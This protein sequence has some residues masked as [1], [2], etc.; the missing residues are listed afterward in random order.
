MVGR[1]LSFSDALFSGAMLVSGTVYMFKMFYLNVHIYIYIPIP[2]M[3]AIFTY[4][5]LIS[6]VPV[7]KYIIHGSLG[8]MH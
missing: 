6:M 7:G 8:Y 2:S 1:L 4:I 5:W 3:C